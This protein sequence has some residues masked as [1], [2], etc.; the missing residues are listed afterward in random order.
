MDLRVEKTIKSIFN[1]FLEM[2]AKSP[3]EKI[4]VARI[5][6]RLLALDFRHVAYPF[7]V[8]MPTGAG[9]CAAMA[10]ELDRTAGIY[11]EAGEDST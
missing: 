8:R 1:A 5:L 6:E 3:L 7:P 4:S 2:R 9:E 10:E 11:N